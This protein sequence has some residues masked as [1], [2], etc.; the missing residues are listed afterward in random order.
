MS[1]KAGSLKVLCCHV[2]ASRGQQIGL[3]PIFFISKL[4][5]RCRYGVVAASADLTSIVYLWYT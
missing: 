1:A 4:C 5:D 3:P 2:E